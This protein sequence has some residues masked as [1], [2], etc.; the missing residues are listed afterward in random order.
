[1]FVLC[2]IVMNM[3]GNVR[4]IRNIQDVQNHVNVVTV[5]VISIWDVMHVQT[6]K[7]L[8]LFS[9]KDRRMP[10]VMCIV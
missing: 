8:V 4:T 9:M 3:S 7:H 6:V 2:T 10:F 1:M 5:C